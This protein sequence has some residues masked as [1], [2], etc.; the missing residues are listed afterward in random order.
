MMESSSKLTTQLTKYIW[1]M[2]AKRFMADYVPHVV[3]L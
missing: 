3:R 2:T 1:E